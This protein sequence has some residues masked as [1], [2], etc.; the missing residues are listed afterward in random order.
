MYGG[1]GLY[2]GERFFGI[3]S[4]GRLFLKVADRSR[5]EFVAHGMEP[6]RLNARM[7]S[8][9]YYEAPA[10]VVDDPELLAE[11]VRRAAAIETTAARSWSRPRRGVKEQR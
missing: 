8:Q 3:I 2:Q 1:H 4:D 7:V 6:F 11:W 10:S 5:A 9:N